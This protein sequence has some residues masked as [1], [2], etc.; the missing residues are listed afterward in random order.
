MQRFGED[1][2]PREEAHH[3]SNADGTA[4]FVRNL[5]MSTVAFQAGVHREKILARLDRPARRTGME[6]DKLPALDL[7]KARAN[8]YARV[9]S[10]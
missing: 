10:K 7:Y 5:S 6:P 9:V 4:D 8:R 2:S 1:T 3:C